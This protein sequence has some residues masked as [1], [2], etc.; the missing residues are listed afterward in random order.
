MQ[1]ENEIIQCNNHW[2]QAMVGNKV[3]EIATYLSDDWVIVGTEGGITTRESFLQSIASGD[4]MHTRMDA[5][6]RRI[7]IY[8]DTAVVT[9]KGTSAGLY[10]RLSFSFY[11]WST[12]VFIRNEGKW[13][14][15]LT[16]LTP[17]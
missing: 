11:E 6:E 7:K 10:K 15:V 17:A 12:S 1:L 9:A 4:L 16:M 2:D 3:E 13:S 8:G 5:D 14:C